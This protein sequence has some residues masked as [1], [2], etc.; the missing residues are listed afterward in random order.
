MDVGKEVSNM[1]IESIIS[2]IGSLGFPIACCVYLIRTLDQSNKQLVEAV[3]SLTSM[4]EKLE[5][6][7]DIYMKGDNEIK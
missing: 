2:L 1:D 4:I 5:T 3:N 6:K 7:I